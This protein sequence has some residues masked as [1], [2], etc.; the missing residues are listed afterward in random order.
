MSKDPLKLNKQINILKNDYFSEEDCFDIKDNNDSDEENDQIEAGEREDSFAETEYRD[1]SDEES[2][3]DSYNEDLTAIN[4]SEHEITEAYLNSISNKN[5][6][7]LIYL[8]HLIKLRMIKYNKGKKQCKN[9]FKI[10][11]FFMHLLSKLTKYTDEKN[12]DQM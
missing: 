7:Q 1:N 12:C 5:L 2:F 8:K 4:E 10:A 3:D 6:K 11:I 9:S